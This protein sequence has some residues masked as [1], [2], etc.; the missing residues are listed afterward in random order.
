[1][2]RLGD[3]MPEIDNYVDLRQSR[4]TAG[5]SDAQVEQ[6]AGISYC[7]R[8]QD[9]ESLFREGETSDTLCVITSGKMAVIREVGGGEEVTLHILQAGDLAGEMGFVGGR[10]HSASLRAIGEPTVCTF[11]RDEFEA[12]I[13]VDPW[14]VYQVMKNIVQVGHDILHRMNAQ[15]VEMSNYI[16]H[17]HGRY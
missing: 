1:M 17:Q 4:L 3:E 8:L 10:P 16:S 5:L 2:T 11:S 14:L 13:A 9:N 7:R 6:L 12:L 15:F